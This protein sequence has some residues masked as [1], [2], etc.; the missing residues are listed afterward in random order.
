[1]NFHVIKLKLYLCLIQPKTAWHVLYHLTVFGY[2]LLSLCLN[3]VLTLKKDQDR[4][5]W[6]S[7]IVFVMEFLLSV[8]F[9]LEL[10]LR[11]W[12]AGAVGHYQ[13]VYGRLKFMAHFTCII[14]L[15]ILTTTIFLLA[16]GDKQYD[17]N[18][19]GTM[20][21]NLRFLQILRLFHV[22][23]RAS[24]WKLVMKV[25][26]L[27][28]TELIAASYLALLGLLVMSTLVYMAEDYYAESKHEHESVFKNYG[29]ALWWG[30]VT[31]T[32]IGYGVSPSAIG[33]KTMSDSAKP[34]KQH[35][36]PLSKQTKQ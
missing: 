14:D 27:H 36:W 22:D 8:Y 28:R 7:R 18:L 30:V 12:A 17:N 1:M 13:G 2:V 6:L 11:L 19:T 10:I 3:A 23:R 31:L 33:Q 35:G 4:N 5:V 25:L 15:V 32:T 34:N 16:V 29:D 24:T 26:R 21:K 20:I 9:T